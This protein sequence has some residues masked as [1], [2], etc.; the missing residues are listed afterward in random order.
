MRV[1]IGGQSKAIQARL[2]FVDGVWRQAL[3]GVGGSGFYLEW[4]PAATPGGR[5]GANLL[6]RDKRSRPGMAGTWY[7]PCTAKPAVWSWRWIAVLRRAE[8]IGNFIN[9]GSN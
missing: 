9:E 2:P 5:H 4:W 8:G 1:G 3:P 6:C 7:G